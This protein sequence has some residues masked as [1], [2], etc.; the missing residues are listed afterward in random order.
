MRKGSTIKL[1]VGVLTL[2]LVFTGP[3]LAHKLCPPGKPVCTSA[4]QV[5][6][7]CCRSGHLHTRTGGHAFCIVNDY[8]PTCKYS[9]VRT[10]KRASRSTK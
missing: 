2:M 1:C 9:S 7:S 8:G 5:Y 3:A 6:H 10:N 4:E